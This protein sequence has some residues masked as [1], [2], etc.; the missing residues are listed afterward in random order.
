MEYDE[1]VGRYRTGAV[2]FGVDRSKIRRVVDNELYRHLFDK[3]DYPKMLNRLATVFSLLVIPFLLAALILPF[4]TIWW[5][6]IPCLGIAW[7]LKRMAYRYQKEAIRELAL[8]DPVAYKFLLL[9]GIIVV[10]EPFDNSNRSCY[11]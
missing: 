2:R 4:V 8:A 9:E 5:A 6:F 1:F 7:F 3:W 11:L 10:D